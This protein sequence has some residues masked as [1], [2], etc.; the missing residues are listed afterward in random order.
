MQR[1]VDA[2]VRVRDSARAKARWGVD[3]AQQMCLELRMQERETAKEAYQRARP[4]FV[5]TDCCAPKMRQLQICEIAL[6]EKQ[7]AR[8]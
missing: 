8:K 6:R 4:L 3:A 2:K 7:P 1:W 5:R